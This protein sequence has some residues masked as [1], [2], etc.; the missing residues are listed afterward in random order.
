MIINYKLTMILRFSR[1]LISN[2]E[3]FD[4]G[5]TISIIN[6]KPRNSESATSKTYE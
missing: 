6:R 3:A 4:C 1:S 2:F 5:K